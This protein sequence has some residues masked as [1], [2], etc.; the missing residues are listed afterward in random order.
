MDVPGVG[1]D[2]MAKGREAGLSQ[3]TKLRLEL[4]LA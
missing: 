4:Q 3:R 1:V 2:M